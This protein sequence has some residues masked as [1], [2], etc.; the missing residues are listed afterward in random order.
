MKKKQFFLINMAQLSVWNKKGQSLV[1]LL[2]VIALAGLLMPPIF[3]GFMSSRDGKAQQKQRLLA[4]SLMK[5]TQEETRNIRER[6][7]DYLAPTGIYHPVIS[8]SSLSLVAGATTVN[9]FGQQVAVDNV[10]RNSAGAIVL[11]PTP[12]VLD[13][14]TKKITT[15]I[16]WSTPRNSSIDHV[17]YMTRFRDNLSYIETTKTQFNNDPTHLSLFDKTTAVNTSGSLIP[18]DGEIDMGLGGLSD[19]CNPNLSITVF[20]LPK[21]GVANAISA[22][23][24]KVSAVT[25]DNS[26]G[27]AYANI[28]ISNSYPPTS[29][30]TGTFDGYKTNAVF[31]END[32]A[33]IATDNNGKEVV[34]I[35]L[36][37]LNP[38]TKKYA[39][40][41]YF[42]VSE[43]TNADSVS[44]LG[45]LG[46]TSAQGKLYTFDLSSKSGS[47]P[48]LGS[49]VLAGVGKKIIVKSISGIIYAFVAIDSESNQLQIFNITPNG[50]TITKVSQTTFD[51]GNGVDI[52]V[53]DSGTRVY[54]VTKYSSGKNNFFVIN[55]SSFVDN[56]PIL[57]QYSTLYEGVGMNPKGVTVVTGNKA[58][59]VGTSGQEYQVLNIS[60]DEATLT[61]C[62]GLNIDSGVN[63]VTSI[64]E[65]DNDAYSYI[66]TGDGNSELK[67]I[68]GGP[69]GTFG[70]SGTYTSAP[71]DTGAGFT[72]AFNR[73]TANVS[74][75]SQTS[76][77]LQLAVAEATTNGCADAN[78]T[79]IGPD[80]T[81][82]LNSRFEPVGGLIIGQIPLTTF[83]DYI[84]PGRCF[85]YKAFLST[86]DSSQTPALLDI[87]I[88]YS[89]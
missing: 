71:F 10:Y 18:D 89:P 58:I 22:T 32:Y 51:A 36:N 47:R 64:L 12:G 65:S 60:S 44:T 53:N 19:W 28:E 78:Y 83:Q 54:L 13:P 45:N 26:S 70:F 34:I 37:N 11:S 57:S 72:H 3:T 74:V 41:G 27:I 7:W 8:G 56:L 82:Y 1:E 76:I 87:N 73:F 25:G 15:T 84:N 40:A 69:G 85:K 77:S 79:F 17:T 49:A 5:E 35:D 46:F 88:N 66:I 59:I 9:G 48:T 20:D 31:S 16:S 38:V 80:S 63:G 62:G 14:S 29:Q 30:Q 52:F 4:T 86:P 2:M 23:E 21:S 81:D 39:E 55:T 43:N 68:E 42:N 33:Y 67:I 61:H 75:P 6:G 24:G 50:Q